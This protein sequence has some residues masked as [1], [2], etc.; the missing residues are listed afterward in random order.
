MPEL[1]VTVT[2]NFLGIVL[3]SLAVLIGFSKTFLLNNF[4][5]A[6]GIQ[7]VLKH[8]EVQIQF[9]FIFSKYLNINGNI[10]KKLKNITQ[11]SS[12]KQC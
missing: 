12:K 9:T 6:L 7:F 3:F 2:E 11:Q 1:T 10:R 4:L 5:A 8:T